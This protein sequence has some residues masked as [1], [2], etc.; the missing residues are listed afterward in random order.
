MTVCICCYLHSTS[1]GEEIVAS[2]G[3]QLCISCFYSKSSKECERCNYDQV[4]CDSLLGA[5]AFLKNI[6]L[7]HFFKIYLLKDPAWILLF[8]RT[9]EMKKQVNTKG[10]IC[11]GLSMVRSWYLEGKKN[12]CK[13]NRPKLEVS[14]TF[15]GFSE[16][17]RISAISGWDWESL[18]C[19]SVS[20]NHW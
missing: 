12:G 16:R 20:E 9:W 7:S 4:P 13:A 10:S 2:F 1:C 5:A 17:S 6:I 18:K 15:P 8:L 14:V 19:I 3:W 11:I